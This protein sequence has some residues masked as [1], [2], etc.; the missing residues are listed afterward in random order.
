MP[1][2]SQIA[3]AI[4]SQL[5]TF[6]RPQSGPAAADWVFREAR[7]QAIQSPISPTPYK[8]IPDEIE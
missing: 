3:E 4:A 2:T 8:D 5:P 7:P 1:T 6:A